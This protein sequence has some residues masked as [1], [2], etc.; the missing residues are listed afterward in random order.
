[1][2]D[3]ARHAGT[4]LADYQPRDAAAAFED[5]QAHL[6]AGRLAVPRRETRR[7]LPPTATVPKRSCPAAAAPD[8][9]APTHARTRVSATFVTFGYPDT[10]FPPSLVSQT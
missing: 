4:R 5:W 1:M 7:R 8:R 6:A 3:P 10:R 9:I 2:P